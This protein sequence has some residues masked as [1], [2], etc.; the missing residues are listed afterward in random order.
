M[1]QRLDRTSGLALGSSKSLSLFLS[2]PLLG[3]LPP[4]T[5]LGLSTPHPRDLC[6][7][8]PASP[9]NPAPLRKERRA[10]GC[11]YELGGGDAGPQEDAG[12]PHQA[13]EHRVAL[14]AWPGVPMLLGAEAGAPAA[15]GAPCGGAGPL[16]AVL[17]QSRP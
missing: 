17:Q 2:V 8:A 3:T 15:G 6:A 16:P 13:A 11:T 5:P 12:G 7:F 4:D 10:G 1:D 9:L 14:D